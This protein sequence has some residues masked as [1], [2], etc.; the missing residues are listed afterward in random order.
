MSWLTS[1]ATT[2]L[3]ADV[4]QQQPLS[5]PATEADRRA[6]RW[7][8]ADTD[9]VTARDIRPGDT[10]VVPATRGGLRRF[11]W[12]PTSTATVTDLGDRAQAAARLA[13]VLR[14]HTSVVGP[15]VDYPETLP[16][17]PL[18]VDPDLDEYAD[19]PTEVA[20]WLDAVRLAGPHPWLDHICSSLARS[21][22]RQV[23]HVAGGSNS[24][25]SRMYVLRG[26]RPLADVSWRN[27]GLEFDG[28]DLTNSFIGRAV[29]LTSHCDGVGALAGQFA[30]SCLG[31]YSYSASK[32]AVHHL[33][34][35]L[36]AELAPSIL[37]NA[38]AP[39]PFPSKM[40]AA[41]LDAV[42]DQIAAATPVKRIGRT[43]DVA[44]AA[45]YLASRATNFMTGA[46]IPLDGGLSTTVG[47]GV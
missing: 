15:H 32:A 44:A 35:H 18:P 30:T 12:D 24:G 36:A 47:V 37:V 2:P 9:I 25:S 46:V 23:V 10:L 11:N 14:L 17:P 16:V 42:G 41:T 13:P 6:V 8:G 4:D 27:V 29:E 3:L 5:L 22:T 26:R 7:A 33:T 21:A 40:M 34:R 43:E 19:P 38:I 45:V 28:G 31:N 20:A 39:G 1:A